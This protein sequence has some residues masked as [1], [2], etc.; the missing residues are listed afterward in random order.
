MFSKHHARRIYLC[1]VVVFRLSLFGRL[2]VLIGISLPMLLLQRLWKR[3]KKGADEF[4]LGG[5]L[6]WTIVRSTWT[7]NPPSRDIYQ[8]DT[9]QNV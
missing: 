8:V 7:M 5:Y 2:T 6:A 9:F 4:E 3:T 1:G